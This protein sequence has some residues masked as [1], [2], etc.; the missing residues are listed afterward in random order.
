MEFPLCESLSLKLV[1]TRQKRKYTYAKTG[2]EVKYANIK[3]RFDNLPRPNHGFNF[4]QM[5]EIVSRLNQIVLDERKRLVQEGYDMPNN[6]MLL[7][8]PTKS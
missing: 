1:K 3:F 8:A 4:A 2:K 5:V 7:I 6:L